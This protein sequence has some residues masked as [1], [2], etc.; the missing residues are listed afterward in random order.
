MKPEQV[1]F[2]ISIGIEQLA[3]NAPAFLQGKRLALLCNQASTDSS[4]RH[5]RDILNQVFPG[6]LTC[7]FSP[8]H[9]FF[10]EKQDNMVE[11][12]HM[13]DSVTG[14]PI[15]SLYAEN[16]KP[17]SDMFAEFDVLLVD[18]I[19]V[20]TRVYTFI[21][22]VVYCLQTAAATGKK[23][24]ILDRPNPIGGHLVEGNLLKPEWASFV[25]L[26]A[27][28]MR[29]G[30]TM[31]ELSLL[32]NREMGI[33]A[34]LDVIPVKGWQRSRLMSEDTFPWV[35]PSPNMSSLASA[36]VYPG[37]VLWEGTN[38]SE[39]RGTTLPFLLCGAPYIRHGEVLSQLEK[40]PLP[41]CILRPL[42]FEP[43]FGK[44]QGEQCCGFQIHVTDPE[45]FRPY[46]TSLA[47]LQ[48]MLILYPD[49]FAYK[50]PPYEY[51]YERLPIDL[52][53][54]DQAVRFALEA[55]EDI[56][57]LE[58]S[59]QGDLAGFFALRDAVLLYD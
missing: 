19:D 4:F 59:W 22:T 8:Q 30:M 41:G 24:V 12:G 51:E 46:R 57:D 45:S 20:G 40:V 55:G 56:L 33:D 10:S 15:Y 37:Q 53:L 7:I 35:F 36:L 3:L 39:G 23:M 25:G 28:P 31:G 43:T 1:F 50:A 16:R 54:G 17:D 27:I 18:L 2:V 29:H 34:D 49:C 13:V 58:R 6:G 48:A 47:L 11:S 42:V 9:G 38:V 14:V 44:W 21:W 26:Y 5:S 32:C 52:I